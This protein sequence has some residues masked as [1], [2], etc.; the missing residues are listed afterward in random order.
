[1]TTVEMKVDALCRMI[2]GT[3]EEERAAARSNLCK[4]MDQP[5][6]HNTDAMIHELLAE[7]GV[8]CGNLGHAYLVAFINETVDNPQFTNSMC[9][10][11]HDIA[12]RFN[13]IGSRVER[14]IRHAIETAWTRSDPDVLFKYFRNI[15]Y[16]DKGKP[17]NTE[18]I[19][20]VANIVRLQCN[21]AS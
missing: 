8:P 9:I 12:E 19:A 18:F 14:A 2:L 1:M 5:T 7:L 10:A 4:L 21:N 16:A 3:S 20:R 15:V 6:Q 17:T 11:Y 13:T